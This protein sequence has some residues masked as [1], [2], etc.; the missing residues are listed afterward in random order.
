[1][2]E[3]LLIIF[4]RNPEKG[5]VKTRLAAVLG[6]E[7]AL[8]IYKCLLQKTARESIG[9]KADKVV[10]YS[11]F[12]DENDLWDNKHFCKAVQK[13]ND[14]G[15][16]MADAFKRAFTKGYQRVCIVGSDC[17][18]LTQAIIQK[19]FEVLRKYDA[20]IGP[21]KDGG[22]YILGMSAFNSALFANKKWSTHTVAR[23]TIQDF[24]TY[25]MSYEILPTLSDVD[26]AE[27]LGNWTDELNIN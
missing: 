10:Y 8:S 4:V 12:A 3:E 23:D 2:S 27:D 21:A 16:K 22:Y 14:L 19:A 11:N 9:V 1:M 24:K 5:K 20:V 18:D 26:T 7:K 6:K 17:Y 13:G 15:E 25:K